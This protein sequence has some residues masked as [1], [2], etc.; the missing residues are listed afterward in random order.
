MEDL[1]R[2]LAT[3]MAA[4]TVVVAAALTRTAASWW[5]DPQRYEPDR[6][7]SRVHRL[8]WRLGGV[9]AVAL[10]L[11]VG[12]WYLAGWI[13]VAVLMFVALAL[14][15]A[16]NWFSVRALRRSGWAAQRR[17]RVAPPPPPR[18]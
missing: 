13:E 9:V 14:A 1:G 6:L 17:G 15:R 10:M 5:R 18:S 4:A 16:G 2:V 11:G 3:V 7:R 8:H 12:G